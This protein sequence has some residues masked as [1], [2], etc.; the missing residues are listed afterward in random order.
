MDI[1]HTHLSELQNFQD[2][3]LRKLMRLPPTKTKAL[4]HWDGM[5]ESMK[6]RIAKKKILF[7]RKMAMRDCDNI[8]RRALMH[9]FIQ[10]IQGL[11][12]EGEV[13][14]REAGLLDQ[15]FHQDPK[16]TINKAISLACRR[17][18]KRDMED[19]RKVRDRMSDDRETFEYL[20]VMPL[21]ESRIWMRYRARA[22]KGVKDN[23]RASHADLTCNLCD[24]QVTETQEHLEACNGCAIERRGLNMETMKDKLKFWSRMTVKLEN[25]RN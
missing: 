24:E 16:A 6:W 2:K 9:E 17:E 12:S 8:C 19:S 5:M 22:I 23:C 18:R 15:R 21:K 25:R 11:G 13:L 14:A 1:S 10:G 20:K 3:F 4:I 7:I